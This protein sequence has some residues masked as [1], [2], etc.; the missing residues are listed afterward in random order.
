M[1]TKRYLRK[2]YNYRGMGKYFSVLFPRELSD[3]LSEFVY[4]ERGEDCII[5]RPCLIVLR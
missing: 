3:A 5:I 2:V 4:V 1:A